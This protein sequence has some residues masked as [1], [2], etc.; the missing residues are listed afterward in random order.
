MKNIIGASHQV[1][2]TSAFRGPTIAALDHN[3]LLAHARSSHRGD[4]NRSAA[5]EGDHGQ[6]EAMESRPSI[7]HARLRYL[8]GAAG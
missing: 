5:W 3:S 1:G 4:K 8:T 6:E 7:L 2:E